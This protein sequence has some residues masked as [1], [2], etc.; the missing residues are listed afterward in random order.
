MA[1]V[2]RTV[3]YGVPIE[4]VKG[5]SVDAMNGVA[6]KPAGKV[7]HEVFMLTD[8]KD[9]REWVQR[10]VRASN[11][12]VR[13]PYVMVVVSVP[14]GETLSVEGV[15]FAKCS[16]RDEWDMR[17]GV[18]IATGRAQKDAAQQVLDKYALV[19]RLK[20]ALRKVGESMARVGCGREDEQ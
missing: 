9:A 2:S 20:A 16:P 1:E 12:T 4:Y 8:P 13:C 15:G 5:T 11:V 17:L 7:H 3:L 19:G 14:V 6:K 18:Q 10:N